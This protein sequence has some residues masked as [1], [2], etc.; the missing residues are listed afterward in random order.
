MKRVGLAVGL[1]VLAF[2]CHNDEILCTGIGCGPSVVVELPPLRTEP[3]EEIA[4][5]VCSERRCSTTRQIGAGSSQIW[6]EI[7]GKAM[8]LEITVRDSSGRLLARGEGSA[9]VKVTRPNGPECPPVC[10]SAHV[11]LDGT[12][13]VAV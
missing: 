9:P 11:R 5:R 1:A 10:R 2:G 3:G 13:L 7:R 4:V 6:M 8:D 12:R